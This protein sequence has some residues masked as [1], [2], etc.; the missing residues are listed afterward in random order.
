MKV[1]KYPQSCLVFE[2]GETKVLV[3]PGIVGFDERFL[4]DWKQADLVLV[5]H[6]HSDHIYE[7][8]VKNLSAPIY[9]TDD[10]QKRCPQLKINIVHAGDK[11]KVGN[12]EIEVTHAVHGFH[13]F[14]KTNG[15]YVE[16][17]IGFLLKAEGKTV[18]ITS[19]TVCFNNNIEADVVCLP[20][21]GGCMTMTPIEAMYYT[22]MVKAKTAVV[23]HLEKAFF[24]TTAEDVKECFKQAVGVTCIVPKI[25][26]EFEI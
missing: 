19:D 26:E 5:T 3:D 14:M 6:K 8:A 16:E 4:E 22:N 25:G 18:Y 11:F 20:A 9:S 17:N 24:P 12:F 2:S 23:I 15:D 21:T 1:K 7:E 10:V 13:P